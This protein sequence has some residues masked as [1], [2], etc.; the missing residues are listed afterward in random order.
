MRLLANENVPG[1]AVRALRDRG[2]DVLWARESMQGEPGHAILSR[3][4]GDLRLLITFDKDF[5]ELAFNRGGDASCGVVLFR[6]P[7][8]DPQTTA[9]A[10][11]TVL[12]SRTDWMGHF[13]VVEPGR[14]RL[15][16]LPQ[17]DNRA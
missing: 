7:T 8:L 10:V 4:R 12:D 16:L 1:L 15:S 14:V 2:H 13:A 11:V 6:I 17:R 5:G 9:H 3:A